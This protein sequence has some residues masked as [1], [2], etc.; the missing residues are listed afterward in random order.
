MFYQVGLPCSKKCVE[1]LKRAKR[2]TEYFDCYE[3]RLS[4][5]DLIH[6]DARDVRFSLQGDWANGPIVGV[7][8]VHAMSSTLPNVSDGNEENMTNRRSKIDSIESIDTCWLPACQA[9]PRCT[10]V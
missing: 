7:D 9:L 10:S 6:R 4:G 1:I 8:I 2:L 5:T 3:I